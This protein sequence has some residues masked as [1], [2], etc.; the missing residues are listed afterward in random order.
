MQRTDTFY[1]AALGLAAIIWI[2]NG[3]TGLGAIGESR[4]FY[5]MASVFIF[6][7]VLVLVGLAGLLRRGVV[8][9]THW[10]RAGLYLAMAA[11]IVFIVAEVALLMRGHEQDLVLLPI[12]ALGTAVG[13]AVAGV[14]AVRE[15]QW[16]GWTR[17]TPLVMGAYPFL[18]MFPFVITTGERPDLAVSLWGLTYLGIAAGFIRQPVPSPT[19]GM[20]TAS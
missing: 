7:H 5:V 6:A 18:F 11:R 1:A 12:A 15:A 10:G 13:M 3:L 14:A 20:S 16:K 2:S 19:V 8:G 17:F 4:E 9:E